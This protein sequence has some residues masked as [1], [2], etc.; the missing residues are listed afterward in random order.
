VSGERVEDFGVA[1]RPGV[2]DGDTFETP[3]LPVADQLAI[4]AVHEEGVLGPAPRTFAWHEVLRHD[5][6]RERGGI[7][8]DLDLEVS[9]GVASIER[10]DERKD[11]IE[12]GLAAGDQRKIELEF[13]VGGTE[14]QDA[15]FGERGSKRIGV[16]VIEAK[17]VAVKGIGDFVTIVRQ[18][19]KIGAHGDNLA[20]SEVLLH[21][22]FSPN[23]NRA[24]WLDLS[25]S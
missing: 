3:F 25:A 1:L 12:D 16:A 7:V 21:V 15:I 6:G 13:L 20:R 23:E 4:V 14:I 2:V 5:I 8:A 19:G 17:S 10:A 9:G 22:Q 11:G 18:L 24:D